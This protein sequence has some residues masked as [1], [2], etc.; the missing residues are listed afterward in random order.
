MLRTDTRTKNPPPAKPN[1]RD[2]YLRIQK[3]L[4]NPPYFVAGLPDARRSG[5]RP[6]ANWLAAVVHEHARIAGRHDY[7]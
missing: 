2:D 6:E 7:L 5:K 4:A 3:D 1:A